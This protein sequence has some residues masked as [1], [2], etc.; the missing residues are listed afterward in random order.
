[1]IKTYHMN[2]NTEHEKYT[3]YKDNGLRLPC[4]GNMCRSLRM[5]LL[6][7]TAGWVAGDHRLWVNWTNDM[8]L[9]QDIKFFRLK[10]CLKV[11]GAPS[12]GDRWQGASSTL[13]C[14]AWILQ[15]EAL[16]MLCR[17][18]CFCLQR[19]QSLSAECL[20]RSTPSAVSNVCGFLCSNLSP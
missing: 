11:K 14:G 10:G 7:A 6:S 4:L 17:T 13:T 1:M 16:P 15:W 12:F 18:A 19:A 3:H 9:P 2:V 20:S 5:V 8:R